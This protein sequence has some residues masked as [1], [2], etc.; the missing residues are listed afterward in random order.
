[1][2]VSLSQD[3]DAT[4]RVTDTTG[5]T[6]GLV[7]RRMQFVT[8]ALGWSVPRMRWSASY[9]IGAQYER[10]NFTTDVDSVLGAPNSALRTGTRYP[11]LF[12]SGSIGNL[13]RGAR[14]ISAEQWC[15]GIG[16]RQLPPA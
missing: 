3:W 1:M 10:R 2:S 15:C 7:A 13:A 4:F 16:Q 9:A 12:V 14:G 11:S 5:K 6:L 8:L